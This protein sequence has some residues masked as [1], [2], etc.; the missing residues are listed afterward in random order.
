MS[1]IKIGTWNLCLGLGSKKDLVQRYIQE[2]NLDVCCVQETEIDKN[3]NEELLTF[4]GYS[5]EVERNDVKRR[6][7]IYVRNTMNYRRRAEL[8]GTNRHLVIWDVL[9]RTE[10][11]IITIYRKFKP[12][13]NITARENFELQLNLIKE[14]CTKE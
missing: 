7:A 13:D 2:N 10:L 3:F 8:E 4:P 11:R 12:Q 6:V 1:T 5:L 14:S 9:G